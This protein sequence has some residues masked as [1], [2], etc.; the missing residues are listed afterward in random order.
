MQFH[1]PFKW[2]CTCIAIVAW[3]SL[4][5]E[6]EMSQRCTMMKLCMQRLSNILSNSFL[7][8]TNCTVFGQTDWLFKIIFDKYILNSDSVQ[9]LIYAPS[10]RPLQTLI[11]LSKL[12]QASKVKTVPAIFTRH[13][14]RQL[15][16][17]V[18]L[19]VEVKY[20]TWGFLNKVWECNITSVHLDLI[21]LY[22]FQFCVAGKI[23]LSVDPSLQGVWSV[24]SI[25]QSVN[26]LTRLLTLK[27]IQINRS[28][29]NRSIIYCTCYR[30]TYSMFDC[31]VPN[32]GK[33]LPSAL[34]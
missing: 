14:I 4:G 31:N 16:D 33:T 20:K 22:S 26:P 19:P 6:I 25:C 7:T 2:C 23:L 24:V 5:I 10:L 8:T 34:P 21:C 15:T 3:R 18:E 28:E 27:T 32:P 11:Y 9:S 30:T 13:L 29:S 1:H 12:P 17:V